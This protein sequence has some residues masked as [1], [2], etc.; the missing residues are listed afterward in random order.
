MHRGAGGGGQRALVVG[1]GTFCNKRS[2]ILQRLVAEVYADVGHVGACD[3]VACT[4]GGLRRVSIGTFVLVKRQYLYFCTSKAEEDADVGHI[5]A[6]HV[7][8]LPPA[9]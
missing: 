2:L 7:G 6:G 8:G 3:V 4:P 5:G 1:V 9:S